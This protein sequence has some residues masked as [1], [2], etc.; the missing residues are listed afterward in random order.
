CGVDLRPQAFGPGSVAQTSAARINVIV[1]NVGA[2]T[3]PCLQILF[4]RAS[5]AYFK[6]AMLDAMA[7]FG[8]RCL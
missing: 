5:L 2:Q 8:G 4:D 1:I 7:E 6:D 3:E